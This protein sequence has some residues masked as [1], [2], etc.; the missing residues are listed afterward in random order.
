MDVLITILDRYIRNGLMRSESEEDHAL[1]EDAKSKLRMLGVQI[2]EGGPRLC[3]SPV[4]R[5]MAYASA[6]YDALRD[7]LRAEMEALGSDIRAVIV[8]DFEKT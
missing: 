6:K 1:A 4:G 8:T 5:V 7:I 2:T 3:A